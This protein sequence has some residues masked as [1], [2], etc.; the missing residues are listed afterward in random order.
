MKVS[1]PTFE[2]EKINWSSKLESPKYYNY[3]IV[4]GRKYKLTD[5]VTQKASSATLH[6]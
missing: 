6:W 1:E 4:F 2:R 5:L 3:S